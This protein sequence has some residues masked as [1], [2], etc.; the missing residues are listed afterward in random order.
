MIETLVGVYVIIG[1]IWGMMVTILSDD[2]AS[3]IEAGAIVFFWP[4]FS[5]VLIYGLIIQ[6][7]LVFQRDPS[8]KNRKSDVS[9]DN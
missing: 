3:V 7:Y 4:L 2:P 5:V 8:K 9:E 6:I 1:L